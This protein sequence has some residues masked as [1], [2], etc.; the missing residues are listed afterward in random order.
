M[1]LLSWSWS[2]PKRSEGLSRPLAK[3]NVKQ[4]N[5]LPQS[6]RKCLFGTA[7]RRAARRGWRGRREKEESLLQSAHV[8]PC[9]VGRPATHPCSSLFYAFLHTCSIGL[10]E[11]GALWGSK[12][13]QSGSCCLAFIVAPGHGSFESC[14]CPRASSSKQ[15]SGQK[16]RDLLLCALPCI[17]AKGR[18]GRGGLPWQHGL[19]DTPL[20]ILSAASSPHPSP[21]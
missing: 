18:R 10:V 21:S 5:Q 17:H 8:G 16:G 11:R 2:W 9:L 4:G 13:V 14:V 1:L 7:G 6:T 19:Y 15:G 3:R 20:D 12:Q